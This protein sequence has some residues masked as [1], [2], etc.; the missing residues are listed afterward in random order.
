[1][2]LKWQLVYLG[3]TY[4]TSAISPKAMDKEQRS[5]IHGHSS[6]QILVR[7]KVSS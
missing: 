3:T 1:M 4:D 7:K 6:H 2:L 5:I